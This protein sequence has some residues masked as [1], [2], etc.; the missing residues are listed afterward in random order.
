MIVTIT[1]NP[2]LDRSVLLDRLDRGEVHRAGGVRVEPGGK[3][4]NVARALTA[5]DH[6]AVA[7][8]PTGGVQG[9]SLA[10]LLA[11]EAVSVVEVPVEAATRSNLTLLESDGTTTKINE[12]GE[13]LSVGE[14]EAL[15]SRLGELAARARWVV[16]SGSLPHGCPDDYYAG[17]VWT[18]RA[19]G[20]KVAVDSSGPALVEACA[21]G[22]ELLAPNLA[23]LTE[24]A[25][26][27]PEGTAELVATARSVRADATGS[28]LVTLGE[29]GALLVEGDSAW[30]GTSGARAVRSTVGAGDAALAGY[31]LAGANG[32]E[33][34]RSAVAYGT[35]AVEL[36][37]SRMPA[38]KDLRPERVR[39]TEVD[40]SD[41]LVRS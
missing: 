3:G 35:A 38:P 11:P 19:A 40:D 13:A 22:P 5:A 15:R 20:A 6:S 27:R 31:L 41:R 8:L 36:P 26:H 33:A 12:S 4:V 14:L 30:L 7:V 32:P 23:E 10:E 17:L 2:S 16:A 1:P 39:I 25:G 21:A 18:A 28:V 34:L 9:S 37:G 24:L 29:H